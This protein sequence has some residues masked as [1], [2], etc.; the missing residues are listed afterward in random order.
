M[1]GLPAGLEDYLQGVDRILH[2][3]DI[4]RRPVLEQLGQIA[5]VTA[6]LGNSDWTLPYLPLKR[7]ID[8]NGV[9]IML[10]HSHGGLLGYAYE[11]Y[12]YFRYGYTYDFHYGRVRRWFPHARVVIFGHTHVPLAEVNENGSGDQLLFNPGSLGPRYFPPGSG[13]KAGRICLANGK[14]TAEIV[15]LGT[16]KVIQTAQLDAPEMSIKE[17]TAREKAA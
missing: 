15:D 7:H 13:P 1:H 14:I 11:R 16:R 3:G 6:V 12:I 2:T 9:A 17:T 4:S 5:P 10:T 8:I